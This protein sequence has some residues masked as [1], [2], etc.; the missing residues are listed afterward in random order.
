MA[1]RTSSFTIW[2]V[3]LKDADGK[4]LKWCHN[5]GF[6]Y[7][8]ARRSV[9]ITPLCDAAR[10]HRHDNDYR[11]GRA[12][13]MDR[14]R[15]IEDKAQHQPVRTAYYSERSTFY[16]SKDIYGLFAWRKPTNRT[17]LLM[18]AICQPATD[19]L[20]KTSTPSAALFAIFTQKTIRRSSSVTSTNPLWLQDRAMY[21]A[22]KAPDTRLVHYEE[23]RD[24]EVADT[25]PLWAT[26]VPLM[27]EFLF[28]GEYLHPKRSHHCEYARDGERTG[29]LTELRT[30]SISTIAFRDIMSG[31][32]ISRDPGAMTTAMSGINCGDYGDHPK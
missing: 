12:V 1:S 27:N 21:H 3:T 6:R 30:S 14:T 7:Q 20:R 2:S 26:R 24:A 18:S 8:S 10:R 22:V 17:A 31:N 28:F 25:F 23:D 19:D 4:C 5:A 32:G 29:R 16:E 11:K 13:G 9:L 15:K